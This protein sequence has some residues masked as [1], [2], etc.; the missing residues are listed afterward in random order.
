MCALGTGVHTCA[1]P[2]GSNVEMLTLDQSLDLDMAG[3]NRLYSAHLNK[4][5]LQVFDILGMKDMDIEAAEGVEIRLA[6]GRSLM[7][8][9]AGLGVAALGHNHPRIIDAER[10][11]HKRKVSDCIKIAPTKLQRDLSFTLRIGID[12]SGDRRLKLTE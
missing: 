9:S 12:L 10:N 11:C 8:F 1:L 7:D 4:Y 2:I 6:D 5:A 3:A